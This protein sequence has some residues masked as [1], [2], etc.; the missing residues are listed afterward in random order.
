MVSFKAV[1]HPELGEIIFKYASQSGMYTYYYKVP[2][3]QQYFNW[4]TNI[5]TRWDWGVSTNISPNKEAVVIIGE[6]LPN[7]IKINI[8]NFNIIIIINRY[9]YKLNK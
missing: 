2:V 3:F 7:T 6:A 8:F 5:V 1:E 4:L 9:I